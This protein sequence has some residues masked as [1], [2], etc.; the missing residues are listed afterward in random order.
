MCKRKTGLLLPGR[1]T[2]FGILMLVTLTVLADGVEIGAGVS[3][4]AEVGVGGRRTA[5]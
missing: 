1:I 4:T 5:E 2:L 3:V